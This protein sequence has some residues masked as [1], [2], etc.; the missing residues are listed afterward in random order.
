MDD[1]KAMK[2]LMD[3]SNR[4]KLKKEEKEA[5]KEAVG[6]L[7]WTMLSKKRMEMKKAKLKKDAEW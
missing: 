2:I 1:E 5:I 3:L 4:Y 6:I 7:S